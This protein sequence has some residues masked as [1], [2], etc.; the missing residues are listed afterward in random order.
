M[1]HPPSGQGARLVQGTA[2]RGA[3]VAADIMKPWGYNRTMRPV[4]LAVLLVSGLAL[5]V[6]GGY[7]W[8]HRAPAPHHP[9]L[10]PEPRPLP[11]FS[12]VDQD[13]RPFDNRRLMGKWSLLFFG[14]THCPDVCPTTLSTLKEVKGRLEGHPEVLDKVQFVFISVDPERD[15]PKVLK[16]YV[17]YFDPGF[18]GATGSENQLKVLTRSLGVLYVKVPEENGDYLVDHSASVILVDPK[19]RFAGVL[20]PPHRADAIAHT[21]LEIAS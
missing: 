17:S 6:A 9:A 8:T 19:G 3:S 21:L 10:L 16:D 15:T 13:G 11:A 18:I 7:L 5:G 12:L 4:F 20:S 2:V 14:Y 1:V